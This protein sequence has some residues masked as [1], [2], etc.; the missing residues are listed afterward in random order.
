MFVFA[1]LNDAFRRLLNKVNSTY[2]L[3]QALVDLARQHAEDAAAHA[4]A[5]QEAALGQLPAE[6]ASYDEFG[7]IVYEANPV[8][9]AGFQNS[10]ANQGATLAELQAALALA[11][12][13]IQLRASQSSFEALAEVGR[14]RAAVEMTAAEAAAP[15]AALALPLAAPLAGG[16]REG[17]ALA[18]QT[19]S[20]PVVC[21][22]LTTVDDE[23]LDVPVLPRMISAVE[24]A[25]V[26]E[27]GTDRRA[28]LAVLANL[29][30]AALGLDVTG[31]PL[32]GRLAADV[33]AGAAIDKLLLTAVAIP[34]ENGF[35]LTVES[36]EGPVTVTVD[37]D[38]A[39]SDDP[40]EVPIEAADLPDLF[41]NAE[42]RL[43]EQTFSSI[44]R[45]TARGFNSLLTRAD[46][47]P[48]SG[49]KV[50]GTLTADVDG[51]GVDELAVTALDIAG[52][53]GVI[54]GDDGDEIPAPFV[55]V[56]RTPDD[57]LY[58][59]VTAEP[60][61]GGDQL[62]PIAAARITAP[63]GS[64]LVAPGNA[65]L[66][67]IVREAG[68]YLRTI[69]ASTEDGTARSR[70]EQ[71][72]NLFSVTVAELDSG[73]SSA[74]QIDSSRVDIVGGRSVRIDAGET[75]SIGASLVISDNQIYNNGNLGFG[76]G[77]DI[78]LVLT[79]PG[80]KISIR[81]PNIELVGNATL[82][83]Q[84]VATT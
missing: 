78:N 37:D 52:A 14:L 55:L 60:V 66:T 36:P 65:A 8:L 44:L 76:A 9:Y 67:Q 51:I 23:A 25:V 10:L 73:L 4:Q 77:G 53:V 40:T 68:R 13:E 72:A 47:D 32:V 30:E 26:Y 41:Q 35:T 31:T 58:D 56:V 69:V 84:P 1:A 59:V 81:A 19:A 63:A 50:L 18:V 39:A 64:E 2:V 3:A 24:G 71:L 46:V 80:S 5:A 48:A 57:E 7:R 12:G 28:R 79:A 54:E 27:P 34:L 29:I 21:R 17:S 82:N 42:V 22:V 83:G 70:V 15:G 33:P 49:A 43:S 74:F 61:E 75:V 38:L 45:L 62:V 16:A 20:G 6:V 11:N